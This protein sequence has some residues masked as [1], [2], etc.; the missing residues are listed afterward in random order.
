[1]KKIF[2]LLLMATMIFTSVSAFATNLDLKE[3][4]I[5]EPVVKIV[6]VGYDLEDKE[7]IFGNISDEEIDNILQEKAE[8]L[9]ENKA[10]GDE[11]AQLKNIEKAFNNKLIVSVVHKSPSLDN[12]N[13]I[14]P[15]DEIKPFSYDEYP[16]SKTF[17]YR[18]GFDIVG[19]GTVYGG[20]ESVVD[21]IVS[22]VTNS[23]IIENLRT[24]HD[25]G[26]WFYVR[27][28][29]NGTY[30]AHNMFLTNDINQTSLGKGTFYIN[31]S[32]TITFGGVY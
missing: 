23:A 1:M 24:S 10:I 17:R 22:R 25:S 21:G 30:R 8:K 18:V 3:V 12:L 19:L 11:T 15:L 20:Y 7:A 26:A 16:V 29:S 9:M 32:G 27:D 4:T 6:T 28:Y 14:E 2:N 31:S 5:N 13:N